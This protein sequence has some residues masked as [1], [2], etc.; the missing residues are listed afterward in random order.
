[1]ALPLPIRTAFIRPALRYHTGSL[2]RYT[3]GS[4]L[5]PKLPPLRRLNVP[6]REYSPGARD[7]A[8]SPWLTRGK[9]RFLIGFVIAVPVLYYVVSHRVWN[10]HESVKTVPL[11]GPEAAIVHRALSLEEASEKLKEEEFVF[12]G[13]PKLGRTRVHRNRVASNSP[14]EDQHASG[15]FDGREGRYEFYGVFDG[16]L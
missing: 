2:R 8:R 4:V 7:S 16:H 6:L 3:P 5:R 9:E 14:V 1:M 15:G 13:L 10:H 12:Q 11:R